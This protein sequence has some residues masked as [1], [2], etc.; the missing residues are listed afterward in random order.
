LSTWKTIPPPPENVASV[1]T[2][3]AFYQ[4]IPVLSI[5]WLSPFHLRIQECP[6]CSLRHQVTGVYPQVLTVRLIRGRIWQARISG[7]SEGEADV[8]LLP[9]GFFEAVLQG[10]ATAA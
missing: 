3:T 10:L 1:V 9:R 8:I 2:F 6:L 4:D 7:T 5:W